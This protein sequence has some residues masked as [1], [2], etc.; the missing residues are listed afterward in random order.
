MET[1][2]T[3]KDDLTIIEIQGRLDTLSSPAFEAAVLPIRACEVINIQIDCS[4][5]TY[6][7]SSGLRVFL[8]IQKEVA[9]KEGEII[10][11]G[12]KAEIKDIFEM[13]GFTAIFNIE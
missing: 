1:K 3:K 12:M 7:S 13:T 11:T 10:V 5:L 8:I 2:I 4:Q 6:I 9:N